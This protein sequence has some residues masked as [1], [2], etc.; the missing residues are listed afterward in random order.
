MSFFFKHSII[1][2]LI[3]AS[4]VCATTFDCVYR[5]IQSANE[6][7]DEDNK[8]TN[9]STTSKEEKVSEVKPIS[10]KGRFTIFALGCSLYAN[11][12]RLFRTD[13]GGQ[14]TCLNGMRAISMIWIIVYHSFRYLLDFKDFFFLC[15][16]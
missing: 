3:C 12:E 13:N 4:I 1:L 2:S 5:V 7:T 10:K 9:K 16:I 15:N 6:E 11:T 14:F 8:K